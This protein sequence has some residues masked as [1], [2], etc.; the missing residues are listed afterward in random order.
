MSHRDFLF[1]LTRNNL[2]K[3]FI[4]CSAVTRTQHFV[5]TFSRNFYTGLNFLSLF[6]SLIARVRVRELED[7]VCVYWLRK[8]WGLGSGFSMLL[9]FHSTFSL[10]GQVA[11]ENMRITAIQVR[12]EETSQKFPYLFRDTWLSVSSRDP[13]NV[14]AG[15]Q[16]GLILF[17][18][19]SWLIWLRSFEWGS[20][21]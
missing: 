13:A 9:P 16:V 1:P 5:W 10:P 11:T 17:E 15:W 18:H 19:M 14:G 3:Q 6:V 21:V 7:S 20:F 12:T 2:Y 4:S 8:S